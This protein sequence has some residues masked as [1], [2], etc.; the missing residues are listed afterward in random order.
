MQLLLG[1]PC[2]LTSSI[3]AYSMLYPYTDNYLDDPSTTQATKQ[4]FN[5]LLGRRLAGETVKPGNWYEKRIFE[6]ICLIEAEKGRQT[7]P[8]VYES[9]QAI[10][11]AQA[12]SVDLTTTQSFNFDD[13]LKTSIEKG[14]ASVLADAYLVADNE[15]TPKQVKLFFGLGAFLQLVDDL[16]DLKDDLKSGNISIFSICAENEINLEK[17]T[18]QTIGFGTFAMTFLDSFEAPNNAALKEVMQMSVGKLIIGAVS[19]NQRFFRREYLRELE[20]H[21]PF[22]FAYLKKVRA[23]IKRPKMSFAGALNLVASNQCYL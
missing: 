2:E 22:R 1:Q 21:F 20:A 16:Q 8:S 10:H 13:V 7:K 19:L 12:K 18:N 9:L 4:R 3:F 15:L 17:M 14:G 6:L 11:R 5:G 23:L